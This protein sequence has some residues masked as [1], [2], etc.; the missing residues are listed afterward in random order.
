MIDLVWAND[1]MLA[2]GTSSEVAT[3][4]PPLADHEPIIST[5]KWS[6]IYPPRDTP[7]LRWST[8][9]EELFQEVIQGEREH[10]NEMVS[11]LPS[12]P[13]PAQLD[14]LAAITT[15][16]ISTALEASTKRAFPRPQGHKWWNQDCSR[17]VKTLRRVV[18]NPTSTSEDIV[19]AKQTFRRVV[20]C[21]KRHF[22]RS[23]V[24]D[25]KE[26]KDVFNAVKWNRTEGS[27]PISPLREGEHLHVSTDDKANY[28]VRALLQK[29]ACSEDMDPNPEPTSNPYLPFPDIT[30]REIYIA[31]ASPKNSTP[32]KDGVSTLTLRKAWPALGPA[33]SSLYRHCLAQGWHPTPFR[34][35]SLVAISKPGK[36]DRSSPRAYRLISLLSVSGKGLERLIGR[37][38]AW[39]AIKHKVL[40]PQQFG[41]LPLRSA[42][43][44]C[45]TGPRC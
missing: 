18:R 37:R 33:I 38:L 27:L 24:D 5:I 20:R 7:T 42:R 15:Q 41:A 44:S 14:E 25:F 45:S 28:L 11:T 6:A 34:D 23:K 29:A 35:A 36:R 8:L 40:H 10:L 17:V 9:N 13:S 16:A 31:V 43:P 22:W 26:P 32:G 21:S 4:L 12:H 2:L 30:E 19:E 3:D 39:I 1:S